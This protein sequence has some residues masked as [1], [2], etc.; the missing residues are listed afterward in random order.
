MNKVDNDDDC[1]SI[2]QQS[3]QVTSGLDSLNLKNSFEKPTPP[4]FEKPAEKPSYSFDK[5]AE[6]PSYNFDKPIDKP[7]YT[8]M[9]KPAFQSS[10]TSSMSFQPVSK[11]TR[12][13]M[14]Q[15]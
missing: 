11:Y 13:L 9:D 12:Q 7:S 10:T 15:Q 5:P 3:V 2:G 4:T 1:K 6:K 14:E 8:P